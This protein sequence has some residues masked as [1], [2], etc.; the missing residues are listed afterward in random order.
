V[1]GR[2]RQSVPSLRFSSITSLSSL[3]VSTS[4]VAFYRGSYADET[5]K[6]DGFMHLMSSMSASI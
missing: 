2:Q 5:E 6:D 1:Y 3:S 4:K